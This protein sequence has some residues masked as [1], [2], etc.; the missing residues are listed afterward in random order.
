MYLGYY[1]EARAW[2]DW[3]IRAVD[4]GLAYLGY[5]RRALQDLEAG[6]RAIHDVQEL[7]RGTKHRPMC[8]PWLGGSLPTNRVR[9]T[10]RWRR[11][12]D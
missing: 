7:S 9:C 10:F 12:E 5:A 8:T 4:A 11:V 2:R 1:D 3:L 6:R